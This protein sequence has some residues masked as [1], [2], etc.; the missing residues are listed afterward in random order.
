VSQIKIIFA[1]MFIR[2]KKNSS[3]S[4]SIQVIDKS[5][6]KYRVIHSVGSSTDLSVIEAMEVEA[7]KWIKEKLGQLEIS[8]ENKP[9]PV[10]EVLANIEQIHVCGTE[11]LLGKI[12]DEIGFNAI[13]DMLFRHLVLFR[14]IH[15]ASK[16][17]TTQYLSRHYSYFQDVRQVYYYMDKL[18]AQQQSI[19]QS[20][21]YNH[22]LQLLG[23]K[24]SIL[25]YDV[26]TL[27]FES[28]KEDDLRKRGFSK[29]G[30]HSQPQIV[31]GLLVSIGGYP[32][33]YDIFEGNKF[34]GYTMLP[35]IESFKEKYEVENPV[36]IA[37][38]GMLSEDNINELT[39]R[40][41]EFILGARIKSEAKGIKKSILALSLKNGE[42]SVLKKDGYRLIINYS[43][44]RAKKDRFNRERGL[45]K[46]EKQIQS[47]KL[48]KSSINNRGYNKY[49]RIEGD[50]N[51]SI[52]MKKFE[53]DALWDGL[54]GYLTNSNLDEETIVNNY[55]ELWNIEKAFRISKH[56]L[57]IRPIYHRAE[58]RIEAHICIS[59]VAYKVYKELE[60]QL[61]VKGSRWSVEKA[62]EIAETIYSV[63]ARDTDTKNY[64]EIT[65]LLTNEQR[66]LATLFKLPL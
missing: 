1:P 45:R 65:L 58:R 29:D 30:K 11:K 3:G 36:I 53:Q 12:F 25:F 47:N 66:E 39:E 19:V 42:S 17:K 23:G 9:S 20:I 22:T 50:V 8:F 5:L 13:P 48:T 55:R 35:V 16:L 31:L 7:E 46:L 64:T 24:L 44:A 33:A 59:F 37:D 6:N 26:T 27:Y 28:D 4:I 18:H 51:V 52:D 32:L 15:P 63:K 40:G 62:I 56:D 57:Q 43:E 38:S 10:R 61:K 41:Y 49:L 21:S 14:I 54:K 60:R 34:E 2:R